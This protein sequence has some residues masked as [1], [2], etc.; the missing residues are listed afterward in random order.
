MVQDKMIDGESRD[1]WRGYIYAL[2]MALA[3]QEGSEQKI[4]MEI[5][6]VKKLLTKE[7]CEQGEN[8]LG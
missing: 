3:M 1:Y 4:T 8:S 7:E 2:R 6:A 5:T